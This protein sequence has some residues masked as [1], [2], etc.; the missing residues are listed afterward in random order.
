[1]KRTHLEYNKRFN[2]Y[3]SVEPSVSRGKLR[4]ILAIQNK[5]LAEEDRYNR[6]NVCCGLVLPR[7]GICDI[8]GK[9]HVLVK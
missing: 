7:T 3:E 8:C 9:K 4:T 2:C 1:M 6:N 5:E